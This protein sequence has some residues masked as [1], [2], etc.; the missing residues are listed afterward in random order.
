MRKG[1]RLWRIV[2]RLLGRRA[3]RSRC[4]MAL[5][6]IGALNDSRTTVEAV[7]PVHGLMGKEPGSLIPPKW[8]PPPRELYVVVR[9][10]EDGMESELPALPAPDLKA[11][12]DGAQ[13]ALLARKEEAHGK[14]E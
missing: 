11:L 12:T 1:G 14:S 13:E 6:Y 3:C 7:C 4:D 5:A 9:V 2:H 8:A 10:T